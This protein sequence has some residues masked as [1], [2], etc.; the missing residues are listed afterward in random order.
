MRLS[1]VGR[2]SESHSATAPPRPP[3]IEWSSTVTTRP[4]LAAERPSIS[5]SSGLI[6]AALITSAEIPSDERRLA[7]SSALNT[8]PPLAI[9]VT[10]VPGRSRHQRPRRNW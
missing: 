5:S 3:A 10:S 2:T 6:E 8:V 7:A 1:G 9:S 4:V